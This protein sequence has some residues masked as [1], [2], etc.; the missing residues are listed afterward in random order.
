[1]IVI[2]ASWFWY[3]GSIPTEITTAAAEK[4]P[5]PMAAISGAYL[6][7]AIIA[8]LVILFGLIIP[9]KMYTAIALIIMFFA[10]AFFGE[11]EWMRES[12]RKP[13]VIYGYMYGN[14]VEVSKI[15]SYRSD[16]YL[17]H[18]KTRTGDDGA[19]LFRHACRSCHT[20]NGFYKPLNPLFD[21]TDPEFIASIVKNTDVLNGNMPPFYGT[22]DEAVMIADHIWKQV[23]QRPFEQVYDLSGVELGHKVFAV[24]CG[25]CHVFGKYQDNRASLVGLDEDEINEILDNGEDYGEGMPNFTGDDA[26]RNA[27]IEYITS[28]EEGGGQ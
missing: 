22:D 11:F 23:D 24:R 27:L 21:G 16:G 28:L 17:A 2:V 19:D 14:A 13:Y 25:G 4:M 1:L 20:V 8:G 5:T 26:E 18:I 10:L 7:L 15:D 9:K 6:N 12:I 3:W